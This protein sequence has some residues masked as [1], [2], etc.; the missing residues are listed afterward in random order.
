MPD[1][2]SSRVQVEMINEHGLDEAGIDGGG[3][4]REFI[5]ELLETGFDPIRGF[6]AFTSDGFLFPN[7]NVAMLH[8]NYRDHYMF[9]GRMLAKVAKSCFLTV[10]TLNLIFRPSLSI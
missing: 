1:L 10:P 6:F 8:E 9:L 3:V 5:L 7:P 2:K 4:F